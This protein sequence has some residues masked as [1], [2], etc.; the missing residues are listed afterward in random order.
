MMPSTCQ[1]MCLW[2]K[3]KNDASVP[4]LFHRTQNKL[5]FFLRARG[6][7]IRRWPHFVDRVMSYFIPYILGIYYCKVDQRLIQH[8]KKWIACCDDDAHHV[9]SHAIVG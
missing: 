2:G 4:G 3:L 6:D 8:K 9:S 1:V 5:G 7:R